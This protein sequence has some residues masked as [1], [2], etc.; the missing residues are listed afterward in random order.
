MN[1]ANP[2]WAIIAILFAAFFTFI[3]SQ[4][5]VPSPISRK[6]NSIDGIRGYLAFFVFLHHSLIWYFYLHTGIWQVPHSRLFTHFGQSSVALFFM[7]TSFLFFSKLLDSKS[8]ELDWTRLFIS[9]L[10][11]LVPLYLFV[12]IL[13]L[14]TV[15][16]LSQGELV[17]TLFVS[18][19]KI[20]KW[21]SFT[22][23]GEPDLNGV[24]FTRL[25]VAGVTWS[26]PY[27]WFFYFSLPVFAYFMKIKVPLPY[28]IFSSL[29]LVGFYF[30]GPQWYH[31]LAFLGGI[32]ASLL[33]R[34]K[35]ISRHSK[36]LL[37]A[38]I[39]LVC[40]LVILFLY[41]SAYSLVPMA[42][43]SIAFT[44]LASGN[45]LLGILTH[46]ISRT[47]GEMAYSIY[48]L[49]G[50]ILYI[51]FKFI[52]GFQLAKSLSV[53]EFWTIIIAI[54]PVLISVCFVTHNLIERYGMM[55]VNSF[56][57]YFKKF[58]KFNVR[59]F[60]SLLLCKVSKK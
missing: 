53:F 10:L 27:E 36:T 14:S 5:F 34:V 9:R 16:Y 17:D 26:L 11:R 51:T 22:I 30:W 56:S 57:I 47:L 44:I 49:H 8:Q 37:G 28:L 1:P 46:A 4:Y 38:Q 54:I 40:I 50:F 32:L 2:L 39:F 12:M 31:L 23:L 15:A 6:Y 21:L 33:V 19:Q 35:F 25:I 24:E 48:L 3:L 43:L 42:L 52:L 20:G 59:Y 58:S 18:L 41:S 29:I 45:T 55:R 7:I 60:C 13:L